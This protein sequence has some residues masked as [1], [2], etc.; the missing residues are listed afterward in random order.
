MPRSRK[1]IVALLDREFLDVKPR[2]RKALFDFDRPDSELRYLALK[3]G[4]F[5]AT[6]AYTNKA[7]D[8]C[9]HRARGTG[10][11]VT[12][13]PPTLWLPDRAPSRSCKFLLLQGRD[14]FRVLQVSASVK[15]DRCPTSS[16]TRNIPARLPLSRRSPKSGQTPVSTSEA[17]ARRNSVETIRCSW[18]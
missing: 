7:G 9:L 16:S 10:P 11:P 17:R 1:R 18:Y 12:G 3:F 8:Q 5:G 14:R 6:P 2:F 4:E 15:P 13:N